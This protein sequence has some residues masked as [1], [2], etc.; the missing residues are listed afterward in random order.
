MMDLQN[1]NHDLFAELIC[2]LMLSHLP[3]ASLTDEQKQKAKMLSEWNHKDEADAEAAAL[4]YRFWDAFYHMVYDDEFK[5]A[6]KPIAFP[7]DFTLWE[8]LRRDTGYKFFD[9]TATPQKKENVEDIINGAFV[10]A[11]KIPEKQKGKGFKW[12]VMKALH[13]DHLLKLEAFSHKDIQVGGGTHCINTMTSDHG[14]SWKMI[15]QMGNQPEAYGIYPGGQEGNPGSF[16]YDNFIPSWTKGKYY[17][18][19]F[20]KKSESN[21]KR[22]RSTISF[23]PEV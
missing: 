23:R 3:T 18:L 20:M 17:K 10:Q 15:V 14:P 21:S 7:T 5:K 4:F 19:W 13:I 11:C 16:Y 6:P 2:P 9:N 12:S 1:D 22:I 8:A